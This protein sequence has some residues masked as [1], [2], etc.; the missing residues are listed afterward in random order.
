MRFRRFGDSELVVSEVGFGAWT[1]A[2][3]WWGEVDDPDALVHAALDAGITFFDTAPVYGDDGAGETILAAALG[4]HIDDVV[5]T[6]KC[7]YDIGAERVGGGHNERPHD[8]RPESVR[9]QLEDS[10]RR[11][12]RSHIDLY[13][14]HNPV[15]DPIV[16]DDLWAELEALRD[17][18]KVRA[19]GVALGPA[20]GWRA[21][22]LY[23][24]DHRPTP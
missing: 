8:W 24:P 16:A 3:K 4:S 14:L 10:L 11:L 1:L 15:M 21:E 17:A 22:G 19:L 18:G 5:I 12:G 6:T 23:A 2:S 9:A 20:I 13:Q 7:G